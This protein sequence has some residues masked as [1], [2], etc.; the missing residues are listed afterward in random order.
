MGTVGTVLQVPHFC[1]CL[2]G[3][4]LTPPFIFLG[5]RTCEDA[6]GV[7]VACCRS[8]SRFLMDAKINY[9]PNLHG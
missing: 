7:L 3:S 1:A 5:A 2:P 4:R 6:A 9:S 8:F